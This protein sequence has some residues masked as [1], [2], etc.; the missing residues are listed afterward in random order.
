MMD[1]DVYQIKLNMGDCSYMR[2]GDVLTVITEVELPLWVR[3][4]YYI[5]RIK[6]PTFTKRIKIIERHSPHSLL[7]KRVK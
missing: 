5:F 7:V 1:E 2:V 6:R 3:V 4:V